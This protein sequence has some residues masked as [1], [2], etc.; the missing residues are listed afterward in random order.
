[1]GALVFAQ[2]VT[3]GKAL[4]AEQAGEL[5]LPGVSAHV[6]FQLV[7][8]GEPLAAEEPVAD[9]GPLTRVPAQVGLQV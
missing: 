9:E 2:V 4:G 8:T 3:P 6:A 7:R 1:M 5:F